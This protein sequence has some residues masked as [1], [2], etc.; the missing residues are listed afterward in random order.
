MKENNNI[1][2]LKYEKYKL[3]Y[4][5]L[6]DSLHGGVELSEYEKNEYRTL[7]N[8]KTAEDI[9][10]YYYG[11]QYVIY[12]KLSV[13]EYTYENVIKS[14]RTSP[15]IGFPEIEDI[16]Y[17]KGIEDGV[18]YKN[19]HKE[20]TDDLMAAYLNSLRT[21]LEILKQEI[22]DS[23][24]FSI[25]SYNIYNSL[26]N[27]EPFSIIDIIEGLNPTYIFLQ[28][29]TIK[30]PLKDYTLQLYPDDDKNKEK[31]G[32]MF[33]GTEKVTENIESIVFN[34][35]INQTEKRYGFIID[36]NGIRI[37]NIHLAGGRHLDMILKLSIVNND[38][39]LFERII[40]Y[41]LDLLDKIIASE[42]DVI[43][44]DFNTDL[45]QF[46]AGEFI[47]YLELIDIK[48]LKKP[49]KLDDSATKVKVTKY[50]NSV[51][52]LLTKSQ[53]KYAQLDNND[54]R[55]TNMRGNTV[56]DGVWYK[57]DKLTLNVSEVIYD[58][59]FKPKPGIKYPVSDHYPVYAK[60]TVNKF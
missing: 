50:N 46:N 53:Y 60:F 18:I 56:V 9:N 32:L 23:E 58:D 29:A 57:E 35:S 51:S 10:N 26:E 8:N 21:F 47:K 41:R 31:V 49:L 25:I 19:E 45:L 33:K 5:K 22:S 11:F 30:T 34:Y 3:K 14:K 1:W 54:V 39:S 44:G 4:L 40:K 15:I 27:S 38:D 2:K 55:G 7:F 20:L 28:E 37:A 42:P 48:S 36:H 12:T 24:S 17:K 59:R 13:N 52:E 16:K 6:R 43:V